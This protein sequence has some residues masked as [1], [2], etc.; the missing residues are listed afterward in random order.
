[1]MEKSVRIWVGGKYD[2]FNTFNTSLSLF[3]PGASRTSNIRRELAAL[4]PKSKCI[5]YHQCLSV[6]LAHR[7]I[8]A[9]QDALSLF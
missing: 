1:M 6:V 9:S 3:S 4:Q 8:V 7:C 2:T 5:M